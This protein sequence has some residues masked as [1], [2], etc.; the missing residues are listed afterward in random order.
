MLDVV[1]LDFYEELDLPY[2]KIGEK[3]ILS[4]KEN[5]KEI[6]QHYTSLKCISYNSNFLI[7]RNICIWDN[8]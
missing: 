8:S 2:K 3:S 7:P 6:L 4:L 5:T 1:P